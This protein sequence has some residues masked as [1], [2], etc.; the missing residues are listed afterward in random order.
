[1]S[2]S[3]QKDVSNGQKRAGGGG[4]VWLVGAG[5]GDPGLVT[6]RGRECIAKADVIVYDHQGKPV[7]MAEC[8]APEVKIR[9]AVFD[10]IARYNT[11]VMADCLLVTNGLAHYCYEIDRELRTY[12]FLDRLP[13]YDE[14]VT[15]RDAGPQA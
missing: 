11:A 14:L 4:K 2:E 6:V 1:M 10:Q 15:R 8:K 3:R 13:T 9:Q 7:L 12:H 5:P